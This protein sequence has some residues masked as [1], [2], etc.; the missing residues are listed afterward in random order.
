MILTHL[1]TDHAGGLQSLLD[2]QIPIPVLYLPAGA[3]EQQ[4]H[5][6]MLSLLSSLRA[7]GTEIR[8]LGRGDTL[9]FPS[10]SLTV[11]WPQRDKVR[12]GQDANDYS[13][14]S[15]LRLRDST[16]LHA[17]D[18]SGAYEM[19][20]AVPA[21]LLKVAH[22]G[23]ASST[24]ADFLRAVSPKAALL[25]CRQLSR[26][27]SFRERSGEVPVYATAACGAITVRFREGGFD[28]LPFL[29]PAQSEETREDP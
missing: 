15:L 8:T 17:G 18:L 20:T 9:S 24:S 21:D 28:L 25:S 14:V 1:H 27:R 26:L 12:P 10:G 19:Y 13:L 7:S 2:D 16:L 29:G 5:P 4:I 23:S 3:E 6:D 11:L 22:H